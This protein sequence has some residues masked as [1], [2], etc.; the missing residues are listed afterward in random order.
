MPE[1]TGEVEFLQYPDFFYMFYQYQKRNIYYAVVAKM[2]ALG[3]KIGNP[4]ILDTTSDV[5]LNNNTKIY[6]F[7]F[8]ENKQKIMLFK[9]GNKS[10]K[11]NLL[12]SVLLD[13]ELSLIKRS[14]VLIAMPERNDFLTEFALSNEGNL[15][16][17]KASGSSS[18]DNIN[19]I[20]LLSKTADADLMQT[21]E[22]KVKGIFLDDLKLK[23]D[24]VNH[25]I[26]ISSFYSK[27]RRG[28]IDGL[29]Y[30][31]W[32][33]LKDLELTNISVVFSDDFRAD[34]KGDG[35][36]KMAFNDFYLKNIVLKKDGG[37][38][39]AAEAAYSTSR[40]NQMNRWDYLYG[41]PFFSPMDYYSY[42]LPPGSYPW[43][44]YNVFNNNSVTRYFADNIVLM[45]FDASG[46]MEWSN[47]IR[48]SQF[49]DNTD[50]FIG[51][52]VLNGGDKAHFI[53]MCRTNDP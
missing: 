38:F 5:G 9:V 53:S 30:A 33:Q 46:K 36:L 45:S 35:N 26:V 29:Y 27:Q 7:M 14:K 22:L 40:G 31:V 20:L 12:T 24:N 50:N 15:F 44:R 21:R 51:Y 4:I 37:F 34:A 18:N 17:L 3:N 52:A 32:D 47:V 41:S 8:S 39:I 28:N 49:D 11:A 23:V 43:G 13:K 48:K 19:K 25:H 42:Y 1:K 16:C 10:D 6:T 2:D